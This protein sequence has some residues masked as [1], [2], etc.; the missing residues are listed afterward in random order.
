MK[1]MKNNCINSY[2][3]IIFVIQFDTFINRKLMLNKNTQKEPKE[4]LLTIK[5]AAELL[6]VSEVSVKRYISKEV[7]PSVKI[8]GARRII[9]NDVWDAF[10]EKMQQEHNEKMSIVAEPENP[11]LVKRE[12]DKEEK[13]PN[14]VS[15]D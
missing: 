3:Y 9:K 2:I 15:M 14:L 7:I 4:E 5:E 13:N 12:I 11:Y 1:K 6:K 10:F 8:G